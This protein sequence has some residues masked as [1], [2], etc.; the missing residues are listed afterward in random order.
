MSGG[1]MTC[2]SC[3]RAVTTAET[4]GKQDVGDAKSLK[5]L[6]NNS[7]TICQNCQKAKVAVEGKAPRPIFRFLHR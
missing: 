5:W 4:Y 1:V 2:Q 6:E 7:G 3:G